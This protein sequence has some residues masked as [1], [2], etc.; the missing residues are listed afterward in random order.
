M[1]IQ[2]K[3]IVVTGASQ[4]IGKATA[5]LL[6]SHGASVVLSARSKDQLARLEQEIP[7]SFAVPTDMR[8]DRDVRQLIEK[9]IERFG[10]I[11]ILI[12]NA[13]QG[14]WS[15]VETTDLAQYRELVELNLYGYLRAM[16]GVI[17]IMRK[18]QGGMIVNVSSMVS[19]NYYPNLAAYASTKY[20]LN[21]LSLTARGELAK[22]HIIVSLIRPKIVDTGFGKN[23]A[24]PEPDFLRDRNNPSAPPIDT[25]EFVADKIVELIGS[26][27]AEMD[28]G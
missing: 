27:A 6:A 28:L 7:G 24:V 26:E 17:P 16:Q 19:R 21:A 14:M 4:G 12:N 9:T 22:D 15:P 18:N 13:G 11:D 23:S 20:A 8:N 3:V 25:P 5:R 10:R 1:D 2:N